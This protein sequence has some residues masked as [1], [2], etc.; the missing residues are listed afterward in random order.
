M[1]CDS[2]YALAFAV[3]TELDRVGETPLH[4]AIHLSCATAF[5][6]NGIKRC[7]V[8]LECEAGCG[9]M[10][11]VDGE[12]ADTLQQ[13]A[14]AIQ[15]MLSSGEFQ[16]ASSKS[17]LEDLLSVFPGFLSDNRPSMPKMAELTL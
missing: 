6:P 16:K 17:I 11:Q 15:G 10:I 12:A 2:E 3:M 14:V 7:S 5:L 8:Q 1:R 4:G 9:Y 13:K